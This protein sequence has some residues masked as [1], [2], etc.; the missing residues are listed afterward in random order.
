MKRDFKADF[1][2]QRFADKQPLVSVAAG[3]NP[4][5]IPKMRRLDARHGLG[6]T[7]YLPNGD[8]VFKS[9]AHRKKYCQ[10]HGLF[11]RDAGYGDASPKNR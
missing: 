2:K 11:D 7:E 6:G 8:V 1:G 9:R 4:D 5:E 3:V 10:A